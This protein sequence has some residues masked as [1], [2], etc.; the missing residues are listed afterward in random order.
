[1]AKIILENTNGGYNITAINRNFQKIQLEMNNK[2]MYRLNDIPFESNAWLSNMDANQKRIYNLPVPVS[3]N[4][5]ARLQDVQNAISGLVPANLVPFYP[6]L[7]LTSTNI[8]GAVQQLK[9]ERDVTHNIA[10]GNTTQINTVSANLQSFSDGFQLANYIS[11]RAYT[12]TRNSVYITGVL[13]TVIPSGVAGF[14]VRVV[15]DTT[16][17]DNGGTLIVASNGARWKRQ[18]QGNVDIQWFG[19]LPENQSPGFDS[20]PAIQLAKTYAESKSQ[21]IQIP[22]GQFNCS[23][24]IVLNQATTIQG[25]GQEVS[26]LNMT[27]T[28]NVMSFRTFT[29]DYVDLRNFKI[30]QGGTA[31]RGL[32]IGTIRRGLVENVYVE[33]FKEGVILDMGVSLVANYWN[34]LINVTASCTGQADP[35]SIGFRLGNTTN[36]TYPDTDYNVMIGCKSFGCETAI[37]AINCI[38]MTI[39]GHQATVVGTALN[40]LAGNNNN[41]EIYAE[42]CLRMGGATENVNGNRF[43]LYNDG[44]LA[45]PFLDL[46]WNF[47]SGQIINQK[48]IANNFRRGDTEITDRI[49]A[50]FTAASA[51]LFAVKT[52]SRHAAYTVTT[53]TSG[54]IA[55]TSSFVSVQVW[56]VVRKDGNTPIVTA[57]RSSGTAV[58]TVNAAPNGDV[59]WSIPGD[60]TKLTISNTSVDIQGYSVIETFPYGKPLGYQKL[61]IAPA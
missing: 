52:P 30:K 59:T 9:D 45:M 33:G 48:T 38:G 29:V 35:D 12:G 56:D 57:V 10:T 7:T 1:M 41:I 8:Q 18:Y 42:N 4:E 15:G 24:Q 19:A 16:S 60:A 28:A 31:T 54:Y 14:F 55:A 27:G 49:Y 20:G 39:L 22:N 6:Y 58:L 40:M 37:F 25:N 51:Q 34:R 3:P 61:F 46:G 44:D 47:H 2:I 21:G 26:I 5:A 43:A 11:L 17:T 50:A 36:V 13:G 23:S 32:D 53:T